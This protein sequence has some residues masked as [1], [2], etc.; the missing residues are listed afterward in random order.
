MNPSIV[1]NYNTV[2]SIVQYTLLLSANSQPFPTACHSPTDVRA[3][4][5]QE[6][7]L[8]VPNDNFSTEIHDEDFHYTH[9]MAGF[10]K[11]SDEMTLPI[12]FNNPELEPL[13]FPDLFPDGKG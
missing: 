5:F 11:N 10:V 2:Y 9:L 6:R 1:K 3:P 8:V 12:S 4:P 7:D 13:L